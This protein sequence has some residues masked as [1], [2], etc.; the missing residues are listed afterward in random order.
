MGKM[1]VDKFIGIFVYTK[2]VSVVIGNPIGGESLP[3]AGQKVILEVR[4]RLPS[5]RFVCVFFS[6]IL[7]RCLP[8]DSGEAGRKALLLGVNVLLLLGETFG[9][10]FV[11]IRWLPE[12]LGSLGDT[13]SEGGIPAFWPSASK[14]PI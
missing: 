3:L 8:Y 4:D 14:S 13:P 6:P 10:L 7:A 11:Y 1:G 5:L 2:A 9:D 12:T